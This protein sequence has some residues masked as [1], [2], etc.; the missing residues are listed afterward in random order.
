[1]QPLVGWPPND[2]PSRTHLKRSLKNILP[3]FGPRLLTI[4]DTYSKSSLMT[5]EGASVLTLTKTQLSLLGATLKCWPFISRM[6]AGMCRRPNV[7][8]WFSVLAFSLIITNSTYV[9]AQQHHFRPPIKRD[10]SIT[11]SFNLGS[12]RS[13]LKNAIVISSSNAKLL[14]GDDVYFMVA[15]S[16]NQFN[17]VK[18]N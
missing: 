4:T 12:V 3:E 16:K 5:T 6:L 11:C 7:R 2:D 14:L 13:G 9:R 15:T 10:E 17:K 8:K 18:P 1:M